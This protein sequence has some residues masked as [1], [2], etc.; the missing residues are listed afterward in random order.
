MVEELHEDLSDH[1]FSCFD[2]FR[3]MAIK[4]ALLESFLF[5]NFEI[6]LIVSLHDA[7][8]IMNTGEP[9]MKQ[10]FEI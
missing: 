10:F 5:G 6:I 3:F 7:D 8:H 2:N 9:H 1:D 4:P